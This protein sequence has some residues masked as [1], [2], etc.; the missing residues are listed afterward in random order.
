MYKSLC[1]NKSFGQ[2]L[3]YHPSS[4]HWDKQEHTHS[5][6]LWSQVV[7]GMREGWKNV[8]RL[9]N[10]SLLQQQLH[11]L[12]ICVLQMERQKDKML[13]TNQKRGRPIKIRGL[14]VDCLRGLNS[15]LALALVHQH[16]L[17]YQKTLTQDPDCQSKPRRKSGLQIPTFFSWIELCWKKQAG[18]WGICGW[19]V[20]RQLWLILFL[21][22]IHYPRVNIRFT[23]CAFFSMGSWASSPSG[24][25]G[26]KEN[27][28]TFK[29]KFI[30][31]KYCGST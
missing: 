16:T 2:I 6:M 1:F 17:H 25:L 4:T 30:V 27:I 3:D 12:T 18:E 31:K 26:L 10:C 5:E 23:F 11:I 21:V 22:S 9:W 24:S 13:I 29:N 19:P 28:K 20:M 14:A 8:H 7:A 15:S